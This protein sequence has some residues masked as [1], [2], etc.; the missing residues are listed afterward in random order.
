MGR[1]AGLSE[2]QLRDINRW[3]ESGAYSTLE[4]LV[5]EYTDA[6]T[7]TPAVHRPDLN[8]ALRNHLD[9]RQLVEL[10]TAIVWENFRARFNRAYDIRPQGFSDGSFC[11]IPSSGSHPSPEP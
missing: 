10:T 6:L 11:V 8:D 5:L 1:A 2:E 7:A 3:K 9:D 4:R